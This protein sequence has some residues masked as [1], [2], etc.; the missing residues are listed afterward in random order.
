M[1][2]TSSGKTGMVVD[3]TIEANGKN[4]NYVIP[5]NCAIT[6]AGD[7]VLS[8]DRQGLAS[9]VE[10]MKASAEQV[11][12]SVDKQKQILDKA[13]GLL[14]ELNPVFK[15][16]QETEKRF[17]SLENSMSEIKDMFSQLMRRDGSSRDSR[18]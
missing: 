17:K 18:A 8:V 9:E 12:S 13:T 6:F 15:E 3:I 14:E 1:D 5:E 16:R 11:L 2:M 10:A 7:I 4:A